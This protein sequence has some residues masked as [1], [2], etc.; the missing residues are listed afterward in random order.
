MLKGFKVL[1]RDVLKVHGRDAELAESLANGDG[2]MGDII[3]ALD[4]FDMERPAFPNRL[5][6]GSSQN[7]DAQDQTEDQREIGLHRGERVWTQRSKYTK[8]S[9]GGS[10]EI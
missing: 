4:S 3:T 5:R 10:R 7:I 6:S 9:L 2:A 1:E 8:S